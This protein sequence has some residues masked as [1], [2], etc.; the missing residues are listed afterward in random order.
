MVARAGRPPAE[1]SVRPGKAAPAASVIRG[2]R[3]VEDR[4]GRGRGAGSSRR[5]RAVVAAAGAVA[6]IA[7]AVAAHR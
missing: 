1:A 3:Q 2:V 6:A 5:A 4:R 7:A